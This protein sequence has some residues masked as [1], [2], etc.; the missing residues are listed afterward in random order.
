MPG[1]ALRSGF[2]DGAEEPHLFDALGHGG[3]QAGS[4]QVAG[5]VAVLDAGFQAVAFI[6]AVEPLI[7]A[8]TDLMASVIIPIASSFF[9]LVF[10]ENPVV[11]DHQRNRNHRHTRNGPK[12]A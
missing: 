12:E 10:T 11:Y 9:S 5:R 8:A 4:Q 6:A 3:F 1:K 2:A 7:P